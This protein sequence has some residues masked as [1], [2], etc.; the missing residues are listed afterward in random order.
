MYRVLFQEYAIPPWERD[1]I[2]LLFGGEEL[3]WAGRLGYDFRARAR[4]GES[5]LC[6]EWIEASAAGSP[7]SG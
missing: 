2:P 1:R 4:A 7:V 6:I 5:G 3:L